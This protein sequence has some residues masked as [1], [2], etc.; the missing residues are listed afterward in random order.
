LRVGLTGSPGTGKKTVGRILSKFSGLEFVSINDFAIENEFAKHLGI[1]YVVDTRKLKGK[2]KTKDRII[3][4]HLLPY[5]VP[6]KDLDRVFVLRCSPRKLRERYLERGYPEEKI[7]E[8]LE[9]EFIGLISSECA[10][11]YT[12][13]K[14][15]EFD[16]TRV[17]PETVAR[18]ALDV[19]KGKATP[20]FGT[21]DWIA[22]SATYSGFREM[23]LQGKCNRFNI[24]KRITR[25]ANP[26]ARK[27]RY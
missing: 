11:I 14:I 19:V 15:A 24:P 1:E 13:N 12:L 18:R 27:S 7:V 22:K 26:K 25:F 8:N 20:T 17:K 9:G 2:I 16:T 3:A 5:V 6:N 23:T 10:K 4:G 21:I